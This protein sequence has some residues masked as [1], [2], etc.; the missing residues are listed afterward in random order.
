MLIVVT[1]AFSCGC[2]T[3]STTPEKAPVSADPSIAKA[4]VVVCSVKLTLTN[5][6]KSWP[7]IDPEGWAVERH[8]NDGDLNEAVQRFSL[9]RTESV[10]WLRS[11]ESPD[12]S[13]AHHHPEFGP[14][15]VGDVM[16][17][18]AAHD[19]LHLRQISKRMYQ[20]VA[21]D[22]GECSIRYAGDWNT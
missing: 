2:G 3:R 5:P 18:W 16:A 13:R 1:L 12:W 19:Y 11:L 9:L 15:R 4:G 7:P 22:A 10:T 14:F 8:Y 17:A 6:D 21:R 20:M